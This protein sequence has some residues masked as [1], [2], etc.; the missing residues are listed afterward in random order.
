M[1]QF[2]K[3]LDDLFTSIGALERASLSWSSPRNSN[4]AREMLQNLRKFED[5]LGPLQRIIEDLNDQAAVFS[6]TGVFLTTST[7]NHLEDYTARWK[8][9]Q[10]AVNERF[11]QLASN[12]KGELSPTADSKTVSSV[13]PPWER[14]LAPSKVPYYIK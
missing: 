7:L 1:R 6:A 13:E 3:S 14:A 11:E 8:A 10:A 4:E 9:L 12:T 2:H 5:D